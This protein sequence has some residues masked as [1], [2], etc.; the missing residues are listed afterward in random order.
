MNPTIEVPLMVG[1]HVTGLIATPTLARE[2]ARGE[3][4]PEGFVVMK[5]LLPKYGDKRFCWNPM[6]IAEISEAEGFYFECLMQGLTPYA[7]GPDGESA[8]PMPVF[9]PGAGAVVFREIAEGRKTIAMMP[10]RQVA[11]GQT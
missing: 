3:R 9:E 1:S 7:V 8:E 4:P 6:S 5:L 2:L 11:G 10:L